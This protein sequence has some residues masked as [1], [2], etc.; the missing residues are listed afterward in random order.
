VNTYTYAI[1]I[2][3]IGIHVQFI[4]EMGIHK[5]FFNQLSLKWENIKPV[6]IEMGIHVP[7][8][9]NTKQVYHV[10]VTCIT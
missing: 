2:S 8:T 3:E 1:V 10:P 4:T 5:Q 6:I 7:V 9:R